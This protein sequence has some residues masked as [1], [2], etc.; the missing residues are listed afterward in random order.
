[1][2]ILTL[3]QQALEKKI[4]RR[5]AYSNETDRHARVYFYCYYYLI[6]RVFKDVLIE[7]CMS[8]KSYAHTLYLAFHLFFFRLGCVKF[9][10]SAI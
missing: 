9:R 8:F 5:N 1:M 2:F 7:C 4:D 3:G 6:E 10:R